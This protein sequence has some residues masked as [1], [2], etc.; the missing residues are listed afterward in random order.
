VRASRNETENSLY[1]GGSFSLGIKSD[2]QAHKN[3]KT[4]QSF[5]LI[6]SSALQ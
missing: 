6:S 3:I 4:L 5:D 2:V 1:S